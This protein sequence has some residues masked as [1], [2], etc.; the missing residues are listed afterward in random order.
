MGLV[1]FGGWRVK[2]EKKPVKSGYQLVFVVIL[3]VAAGSY[4]FWAAQQMTSDFTINTEHGGS[5]SIVSAAGKRLPRAEALTFKDRSGKT[6]SIES[7]RGKTVLLNFWATWC[8]P[9][10]DELPS[11]AHFAHNAKTQLGLE[12]VLV[13]V[14]ESWKTIDDFFKKN[15]ITY[16]DGRTWPVEQ[17]PFVFY[18]DAEGVEAKKFGTEKYPETYLIS[19]EGAILKRFVGAQNWESSSVQSLLK[20]ALEKASAK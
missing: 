17:L 20:E 1:V 15:H 14:D 9:C 11:L 10:V 4:W 2:V 3:A 6:L 16:A 5:S 7:L 13:S 8:P 18:L 19:K 12:T